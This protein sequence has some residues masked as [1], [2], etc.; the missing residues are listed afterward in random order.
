[1]RPRA[2]SPS[3]KWVEMIKLRQNKIIKKIQPPSLL[4][5]LQLPAVQKHAP[6]ALQTSPHLRLTLCSALHSASPS[7]IA[8]ANKR[9]D[10]T[11]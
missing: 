7:A 6:D 4:L 5:S 9:P 2:R 10:Q 8:P 3:E 1:V 11:T